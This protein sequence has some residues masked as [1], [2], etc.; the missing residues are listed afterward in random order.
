MRKLEPRV[1]VAI[2]DSI[3]EQARAQVDLLTPE[4]C[5]LKVGS[6]LFARYGQTFVEELIQKGYRVFLDLK[7]HDIPQTVA[8]ACQAVAELGVWMMNIHIAG[9]RA[10]L[11]TVVDMLQSMPLKKRPFL[12]G[13][14]IL[15]SLDNNDLKSLGIHDE[16]PAVV[17]RM[18]ALAKESGLN[19]V[20]CSSQEAALLR[21]KFDRDFLLVTPG[22]RLETDEKND[23]KRTMTPGEAIEAGS[24]YLVIGRSITRSKN[25]LKTLEVV[26][27][28]IGWR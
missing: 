3:I 8:G 15:T 26:N 7:F 5:H 4:L 17:S 13:V 23:Q 11:K 14:T 19:G 16:L 28:E 22:I 2:D 1:I 20:I 21:K 12:M 9:G 25:P 24:D 10:M 6:I 27:K 18:A